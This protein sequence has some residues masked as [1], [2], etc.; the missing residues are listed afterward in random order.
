MQ[1]QPRFK[2]MRRLLFPYSGEEPLTRGQGLRVILTW[3]LFFA[4]VMSLGTLPIVVALMEPFSLQKTAWLFLLC[5]LS[6][7]VIFGVLALIVVILS[8]RTAHML[9]R[10]K[11]AQS[12]S[13]SGGRY[14]S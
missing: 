13:T 5:F 2:L 9:Q 10:R 6:G 4:L 8:N 14:G 11:A 12:S 3:A 1:N 7:A